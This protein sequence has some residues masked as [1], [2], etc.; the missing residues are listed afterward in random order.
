VRRFAQLPESNRF[1]AVLCWYQCWYV[2]AT[3]ISKTEQNQPS[4]RQFDSVSGTTL[5]FV[6][7][8][9]MLGHAAVL[10]SRPPSIETKGRP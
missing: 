1:R 3:L 9:V 7:S 8:K 4:D 10:W 6:R 2:G 5:H